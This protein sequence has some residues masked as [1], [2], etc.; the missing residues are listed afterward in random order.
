VSQPPPYTPSHS[1]IS[2]VTTGT[3]PGQAL[4]VEFNAIDAVIGDIEENLERIQRDDGALANGIVTFDS[5]S[6]SLQTA[7]LAPAIAWASGVSY[8]ANTAV[9]INSNLYR[10]AVAHTSGVFATD[11]AA[12]DWILVAALVAGPTGPIGSTGAT[13]PT[14]STG[15]TG[16]AGATGATGA[17]GGVTSI[18]GTVGVFTTGNGVKTVGSVIQI[19]YAAINTWFGDQYFKSGRPWADVCAYGAVGNNSTDCTSAIQNAINAVTAIGG[20]V[21]Y[22]PPGTY[23]TTSTLT[24]SASVNLVGANRVV[25]SIFATSADFT[26]VSFAAS[27]DSASI[28]KL[29]VFGFQ[30]A[31]ASQP[32]VVVGLNSVVNMTDARIWGGSTALKTAGV[33]G[34]ITN[35]YLSG[36]SSAEYT[37][38]STGANFW[39]Q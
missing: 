28:E 9:T 35:V 34:R 23:K 2:D 33:D 26:A 32:T 16:S 24:V 8:S 4:D 17:P 25:S 5:L 19:N 22:F 38:D 15:A 12:G 14:G 37:V 3:F 11:L 36:W 1:F 39:C 20:G 21:V 29:S 27:V 13:G 6:A 31:A 18:D 30:N 10:S 7:G